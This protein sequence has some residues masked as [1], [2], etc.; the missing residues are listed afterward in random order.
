[1]IFEKFK[2]DFNNLHFPIAA[3]AV[4]SSLTEIITSFLEDI[5][6]SISKLKPEAYE[7]EQVNTFI[8]NLKSNKL[9]YFNGARNSDNFL[10]QNEIIKGFR[11]IKNNY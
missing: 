3:E 5:T 7:S 6:E 10:Y 2:L 11:N 8:T 9:Y 1:M 4:K